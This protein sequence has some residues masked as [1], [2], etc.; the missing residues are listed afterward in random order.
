MFWIA[1]A[2]V[3]QTKPIGCKVDPEHLFELWWFLNSNAWEPEASR[4][5][6]KRRWMPWVTEREFTLLPHIFILF[7]TSRDLDACSHSSVYWFK[8]LSLL[9]TPSQTS[10]NNVLPT[11]WAFFS[12][13]KLIHKINYHMGANLFS[14]M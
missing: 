7:R 8:C 6:G 10:S 13:V 12:Q 9:E 1:L 14:Y 4:S 5:E 2:M 3:V 11:T